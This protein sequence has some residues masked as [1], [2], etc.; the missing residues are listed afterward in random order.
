MPLPET[1][2]TITLE[3][4]GSPE[5]S[6]TFK[7]SGAIPFGEINKYEQKL[8][9][10]GEDASENERTKL[11]FEDRIVAWDIKTE[12]GFQHPIPSEDGDVVWRIPLLYV[13]YISAMIS[14]DSM[15]DGRE[16]TLNLVLKRAIS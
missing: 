8:A 11:F 1:T 9:A 6:V 13:E 16:E 7:R 2:K 10:L 15:E 5:F 12:E 4:V 3:A 14:Q